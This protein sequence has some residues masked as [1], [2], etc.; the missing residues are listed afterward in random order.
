VARFDPAGTVEASMDLA[1][2]W[3]RAH[4]RLVA[5]YTNRHSLFED[6]GQ[7]QPLA[8]PDAETQ[9]RRAIG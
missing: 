1:E 5:V 6:H 8:D 2:R 3:V 4:G 7:R 9:F